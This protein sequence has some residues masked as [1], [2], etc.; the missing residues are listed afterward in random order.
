MNNIIKK[1][2]RRKPLFGT[3][4]IMTQKT[5][6]KIRADQK[7]RQQHI[8]DEGAIKTAIKFHR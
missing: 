4:D 8:V 3:P 1:R 2:V 7:N 6:E 5:D